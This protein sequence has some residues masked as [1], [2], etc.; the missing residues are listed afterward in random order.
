[1]NAAK[2]SEYHCA[3]E[4]SIISHSGCGAEGTGRM[5]R[6]KQ[7]PRSGEERS[8]WDGVTSW[9]CPS[10]HVCGLDSLIFHQKQVASLCL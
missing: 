3:Q 4:I 2:G 10:E 6:G 9:I 1:M 8:G 7:L 5:C